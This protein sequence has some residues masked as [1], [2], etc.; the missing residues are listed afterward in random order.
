M[1]EGRRILYEDL[2]VAPSKG[3]LLDPCS[4][5]L[6]EILATDELSH[7]RVPS[8]WLGTADGMR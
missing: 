4:L 1:K 3:L 8:I 2:V 6:P 5:G 7:S